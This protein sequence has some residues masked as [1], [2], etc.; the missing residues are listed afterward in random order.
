MNI[1]KNKKATILISILLMLSMSTSMMLIPS[2]LAHTPAWNITTY[3]FCAVSPDPVGI[4]QTLSVNLWINMPTPTATGAYGD[5]YKNMT[6]VVTDPNGVKT[7][8]GPFT[9]DDTGGTHT[10]YTP[11]V[12][13]NYTFVMVYPGQTLTGIPVPPAGFSA[14]TGAFIGDYM[15][16]SASN[17]ATVTVQNTTVAYEA[18]TPLPT[19]YW[20]RPINAQN[21]NWYSLG[22]NWLGFLEMNF[23]RTGGYNGSEN[24]NAYTTAPLA[25][26]VLWTK[27][28]M[29]GGTIGGEFG[30]SETGNYYSTAQYEPRWAPIVMDGIEYYTNYPSSSTNPTGWTAINLRTGLTLWTEDAPLCIPTPNS[31]ANQTLTPS[32]VLENPSEGACSVLRC[33]Q[34]LDFTSPNQ[35]GA[36][37]YLWSVGTLASVAAVTGIQP[38]TICLNMFDAW[39]GNYILS[40][41]N[42]SSQLASTNGGGCGLTEDANG[43]LIGYYV[44]YTT[45]TQIVEGTPYTNNATTETL[46]CWNST[47]NILY[48]GGFNPATTTQSWSWRPIQGAILNAQYGVT[49]ASPVPMTLNGNPI[50]GINNLTV[51]QWGVFAVDS[52]CVLLRTPQG[53]FFN[54]GFIYEA[55]YSMATG[56]QLWVA[57]KTEP[58]YTLLASS[59]GSF[60]AG[61]GVFVEI[62]QGTLSV[63]CYSMATDQLLWGPL[64]L[65]NARPFDSLGINAVI[66][67]G[68]AYVYCYGGD[69]YALNLAN[70][71]VEWQYHTPTASFESPYGYYSIWVFNSAT[72]AGGLLFIPERPHVQPTTLPRMPI[73][74]FEHYQRTSRMG[75]ES[76][77]H[78]LCSSCCR[79]NH[80]DDEFL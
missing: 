21:N 45:G 48:P 73:A 13:G 17:T 72:V 33:G 23:G 56:A 2:T 34:I 19:S 52:G 77:R 3:A 46:E 18:Q 80:Y 57:N 22:G 66:A 30:G 50:L 54:D 51:S 69:V 12:A 68:T 71:A 74:S 76:F 32:T 41:V 5:E 78:H 1:A 67:N 79:W 31:P 40:I 6:I 39:T 8:L 4:G 14:T 27:P 11:T 44:N 15:E 59:G 65:P 53:G 75:S 29:N 47:Q 38:G 20:T 7:T 70:G 63:Y 36:L 42:C 16:P 61:D 62:P 25:A 28:I 10:T 24:Y 60:P 9:S 49:W 58:A 37:G 64:S 35:Y 55:S 43:D 26:H